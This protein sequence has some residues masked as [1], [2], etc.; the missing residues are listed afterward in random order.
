[1]NEYYQI[2]Q[3]EFYSKIP[4]SNLLFFA[5]WIM[6]LLEQT[7]KS[8]SLY[9]TGSIPV[10][11]VAIFKPITVFKNPSQLSFLLVKPLSNCDLGKK[12]SKQTWSPH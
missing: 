10:K 2:G 1:M 3:T 7:L 6:C 11:F 5:L 4:T 12:N 8:L 9:I